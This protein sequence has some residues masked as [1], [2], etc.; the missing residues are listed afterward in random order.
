MVH[1]I[2]D[3]YYDR[4]PHHRRSTA[5]VRT[6]GLSANEKG[7]SRAGTP[8]GLAASIP[9]IASLPQFPDHHPELLHQKQC[10]RGPTIPT[11]PPSSLSR[12]RTPDGFSSSASTLITRSRTPLSHAETSAAAAAT[13]ASSSSSLEPPA[14]ALPP[15][16]RAITAPPAIARSPQQ[17]P[18]QGNIKKKRASLS[19]IDGGGAYFDVGPI[20][21]EPV[22]R[23]EYG[24]P[25]KIAQLF[26]ELALQ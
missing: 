7:A 9:S 12:S 13:A 26:P 19:A 16:V 20:A 10:F 17:P 11:L 24:N 1:P 25:N 2:M 5:F 22:V 3:Q 21:P 23:T 4:S 14:P 15:D 6:K 18:V 8:L